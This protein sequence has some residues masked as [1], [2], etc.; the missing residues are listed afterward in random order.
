[1]S[2]I[3]IDRE[4]DHINDEGTKW[5]RLKRETELLHEH[6]G[7]GVPLPKAAAWYTEK[8]DGHKMYVITEGQDVL[9]QT[10]QLEGVCCF[11]ECIR[12][13]RAD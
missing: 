12:M 4:P 7:I 10:Q 1:M 11:I 5:W 13:A 8:K 9:N 6:G 2:L 3:D